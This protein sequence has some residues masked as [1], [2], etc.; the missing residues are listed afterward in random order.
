MKIRTGEPYSNGEKKFIENRYEYV[1]NSLS[2]LCNELLYEKCRP[3]M[4]P[5]ISVATSGGGYRALICSLALFIAFEDHGLLDMISYVASLSGSSWFLALWYS[6][7]KSLNE[8]KIYIRNMVSKK[9]FGNIND[10]T[11]G[12]K[13]MGIKKYNKQP[14]SL[15]DIWGECLCNVLFDESFNKSEKTISSFRNKAISGKYPYPIFTAITQDTSSYEW[16]EF[17]PFEMNI[18][19]YYIDV[20]YSN[21]YWV[22]SNLIKACPEPSLCNMLGIFGSAFAANYSDIN[23][24][25][26]KNILTNLI[27]KTIQPLFEKY[28]MSDYR[29]SNGKLLNPLFGINND[30]KSVLDVFDAG[31][32]FNIPIIP[33]LNRMTDIIIIC[34]ATDADKI[35][36]LNT[37]KKYVINKGQKFPNINFD[38]IDINKPQIIKNKEFPHIIYLPNTK[39]YSTFKLHYTN[40]EFDDLF[41]SMYNS[42]VNFIPQIKE[43][44][45]STS[46]LN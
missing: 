19:G 5:N 23:R 35:N 17:N 3:N 34:D 18:N 30:E 13:M 12:V 6:Y 20:K 15:V 16:I 37:M 39:K 40:E 1:S 44:I 7:D 36:N 27:L 43:F 33:I 11:M 14:I 21:S 25:Y 46:Y 24:I 28:D 4:I 29:L 10:I 32:S 38:N 45:F 2:K 22:N 26:G 31:I 41:N 42:I 9:M 8:L